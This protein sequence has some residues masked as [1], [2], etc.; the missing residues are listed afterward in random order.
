MFVVGVLYCVKLLS[1]ETC[2]RLIITHQQYLVNYIGYLIKTHSNKMT[3][4]IVQRVSP[5][6]T[7]ILNS[8]FVVGV[9]YCVQLLSEVK[10]VKIILSFPFPFLCQCVSLFYFLSSILLEFSKCIISQNIGC[11]IKTQ[12]KNSIQTIFQGSSPWAT[13]ILNSMFVLGLHYCVKLLS[14]V[15]IFKISL[16][17]PFP[18]LC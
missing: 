3:Q 8:M 15:K 2:L 17:F 11:L 16:S 5:W 18:F 1:E 10:I 4:T 14:E 13:L 12:L 6:A 9:H 7:L